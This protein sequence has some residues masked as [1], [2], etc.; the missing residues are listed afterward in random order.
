VEVKAAQN[1]V[2]VTLAS[3]VPIGP[4]ADKFGAPRG[5]PPRK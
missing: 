5:V 4:L 2:T 3:D 1:N